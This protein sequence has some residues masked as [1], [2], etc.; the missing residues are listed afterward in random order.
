MIGRASHADDHAAVLQSLIGIEQAGADRADL[1]TH[2]LRHQHVEPPHLARL[3]VVVQK[4]EH[5]P[6]R[7]LGG[8]VVEL[9]T[10]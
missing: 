10:N 8:G 3:D 6:G 7:Q 5:V 1:G 2:R 4:Q 9:R